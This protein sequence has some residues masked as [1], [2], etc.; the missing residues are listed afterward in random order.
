[1]L[2]GN[3]WSVLQVEIPRII[4]FGERSFFLT[5]L[6]ISIAIFSDFVYRARVKKPNIEILYWKI[7]FDS[8]QA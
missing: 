5:S 8:L 7:V 1:M 3:L 4:R 6:A 2:K